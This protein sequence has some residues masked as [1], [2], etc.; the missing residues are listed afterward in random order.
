MIPIWKMT[1]RC[2]S[3]YEGGEKMKYKGYWITIAPADDIRRSDAMGNE[4]VCKGF[5]IKVFKD[6]GKT[7]LF[8]EFSAA[9]GHEILENSVEEAEQFAK[10]TIICEEKELDVSQ[11][12]MS[13]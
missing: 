9:V 1:F 13:M 11:D 10:D 7:E 2:L 4:T 12:E 8:D 6:K 3:G 5:N